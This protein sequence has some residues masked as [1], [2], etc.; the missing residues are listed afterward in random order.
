MTKH[1]FIKKHPQ[2]AFHL[3]E[4]A[5]QLE[6]LEKHRES[7][8]EF[9]ALWVSPVAESWYH[10]VEASKKEGADRRGG[11]K[12]FGLPDFIRQSGKLDHKLIYNDLTLQREPAIRGNFQNIKTGDFIF[13]G[14]EDYPYN[15]YAD[16]ETDR[17]ERVE[18]VTQ[19]TIFTFINRFSRET[20]RCLDADGGETV[21]ID[22]WVSHNGYQQ[23]A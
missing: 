10:V 11:I 20:G 22:R 3:E 4:C 13:K 19:K 1:E 21:F 16:P 6:T 7:A 8:P 14:D 23:S 15:S 12:L 2:T 9:A 5:R 18:K 17:G